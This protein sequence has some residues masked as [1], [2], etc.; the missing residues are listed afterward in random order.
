LDVNSANFDPKSRT[1]QGEDE[2]LK[3]LSNL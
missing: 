3:E 1:L 2:F